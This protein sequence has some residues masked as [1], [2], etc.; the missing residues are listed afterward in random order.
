MSTK[1]EYGKLV[2]DKIPEIIQANGDTCTVSVLSDDAYRV[3]L[4]EKLQE[5]TNE[6]LT[7]APQDR[8]GEMADIFAVLLAI[9]EAD[10][11]AKN[12]LFASAARKRQERGGFS[13][14]L[15]LESTESPS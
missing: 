12:D 13:Q 4:Q 9:V 5:E 1:T 14:K 2:R 10:G 6:L 7:A 11:Y 3:A 15:W 8:L